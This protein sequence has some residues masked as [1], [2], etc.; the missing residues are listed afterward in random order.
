LTFQELGGKLDSLEVADMALGKE[1]RQKAWSRFIDSVVWIADK[2]PVMRF[3]V[4][5]AENRLWGSIVETRTDAI[6]PAQELKYYFVRNLLR[7]TEN[8]LAKGIM[9]KEVFHKMVKVFVRN[10]FVEDMSQREIVREKREDAVYPSYIVISPTQLCNLHCN[11]CYASS[12]SSTRNSLPYSV[13]KRIIREK[14]SL[15]HSRFTVI[16]GGEPFFWKDNGKGIIDLGRENND[17]FFMVYTNGTLIDKEMAARLADVGNITPAISVEGFEEKTDRRRGKGTFKKIMAAF[18]N[19]RQAG[20]PFGISVVAEK[21]NWDEVTSKEFLKFYFDEQGVFYGWLFQYMPIG[22]SY[23]LD[24]MVTAEQR[25][26]MFR[27]NVWAIKEG[28]NYIDFWNQGVM[29]DGCLAGGRNGGYLYIDW[30]GNVMP[31]VFI[32]YHQDNILDIYKRGGTLDD[33]LYSPYFKQIR[34]WQS[35]YALGKPAQEK[36]NLILPCPIRD[37]HEAIYNIL[38]STHEVGPADESARECIEDESY[39]RGLMHYDQMLR[40]IIDPVWETEYKSKL[41]NKKP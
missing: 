38:Q 41:N 28:Y 34:K 24:G 8:H 23:T 17:N 26:E 19:L 9:S 15:W 21:G 11:G 29:T 31:C 4:G 7:T 2:R 30:N 40:E 1:L 5:K 14:V 33:V 3:L 37:H 6:R 10:V 25:L 39:H 22:R 27:R 20:V 36:D 13:V 16:S 32:P 12:E 18:E 35:E